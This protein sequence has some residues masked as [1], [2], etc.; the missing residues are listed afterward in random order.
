MRSVGI[1]KLSS[2]MWKLCLN[3]LS[4]ILSFNSVIPIDFM[5]SFVIPENEHD[6]SLVIKRS[7]FN[8]PNL[9]N[10]SIKY[11]KLVFVPK[12]KSI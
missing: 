5:F 10:V 12:P 3:S 7:S 6:C 4:N 9:H 1:G 2:T 8:V 11:F